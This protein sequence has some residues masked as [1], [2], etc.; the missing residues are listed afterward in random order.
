VVSDI[1]KGSKL[2]LKL[3]DIDKN[4]DKKLCKYRYTKYLYL[5]SFIPLWNAS[6]L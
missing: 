4:Q 1:V 6:K 2:K 3:F 5:S